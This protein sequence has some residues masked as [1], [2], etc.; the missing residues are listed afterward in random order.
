MGSREQAPF[1][2]FVMSV[3]VVMSARDLEMTLYGTV[4]MNHCTSRCFEQIQGHG[5]FTRR[6]IG[7]SFSELLN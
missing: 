6:H 2:F 1:Q 7:F 3:M 5:I 4:T